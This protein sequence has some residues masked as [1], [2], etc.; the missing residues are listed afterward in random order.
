MNRTHK[1]LRKARP[2]SRSVPR[3]GAELPKK[4]IVDSNRIYLA[5]KYF[6]TDLPGAVVP[7]TRLGNIL[8]TL[9]QGRPLS[10]PALMYLQQQGLSAL[11]EFAQGEIT[12]D[13]FRNIAAGELF[14]REHVAAAQ[15]QKKE[16]EAKVQEAILEA[17]YERN[18]LRAEEERRKRE[19]DPKY[20]AKKKNQQ[21]RMRYG[22][23]QF[24][25]PEFFSRLMSILRRL[26]GG[27][28]LTDEDI[29]WLTTD[30]EDYYTDLLQEAFHEREAE[31]YKD[32][33]KRTSDPWNAVNASGHYRKCNQARK[34][35]DLLTS[36]PD[37]R[38]KPPKLN[39]AICTTHGGVM[40]DLKRFDEAL[41]LGEQAHALTPKDFRPCTLLGAV[42][43][44]IGNY[45]IGKDWYDK[46]EERGASEGSIDFDL[47]G[48]LL[49]ADNV[50]RE[51]L[52]S[53]L[54]REDPERYKWVLQS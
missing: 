49:R 36:I 8:D 2:N 32:E 7:A 15:R 28:R 12:Y 37:G 11:H 51:K 54:L 47:R 46:A 25:E 27:N 16:K 21:L 43:I 1:I 50:K 44:E 29:L 4:V 35:H 3:Y 48:I 18:R 5:S 14:M 9:E 52:K 23:D 6:V 53:F 39:S 38:R 34:A 19:S 30:G 42:N 20:I 40:R 17:Q 22:L 33:Y 24:I 45:G 41:K 13:Y 26:D 31:F 10:I